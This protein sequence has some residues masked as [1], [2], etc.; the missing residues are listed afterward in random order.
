MKNFSFY[1]NML[2]ICFV[3]LTGTILFV[4][5]PFSFQS[6]LPKT[7]S[8][9]CEFSCDELVLLWDSAADATKCKE[10]LTA[11]PHCSILET[12]DNYM[13]ISVSAAES[14]AD[15]LTQIRT[16]PGIKAADPNYPLEL[17][18][19]DSNDFATVPQDT[20][21]NMEDFAAVSSTNLSSGFA[22][23]CNNMPTREVVVA[24][25]DTGVDTLHPMLSDFIWTNPDEIPDDG[26]DNDNN[27]YVDDINGW[28]FYHDDSSICHY[29]YSDDGSTYFPVEDDNDNH[30]THVAGIIASVLRGGDLFNTDAAPV[31]VKIMPLKIH[32][33]EKA[34]GSVANAIK[35]IKYAVMMDADVFNISWG[36]SAATSSI[37]TLEQTIR[38]SDL[39][40]LCAAGNTGSDN[41]LSPV[42]PASF[43]ADNVISVTFVNSY[44]FL[45]AK[46]NYGKNSVDIAAPGTDIYSTVVGDYAYMSGSSMSV[47]YVSGLAALIYSCYDNLYPATVREL[48]LSTA[49][50]L[51]YSNHFPLPVSMSFAKDNLIVPG[52]PNLQQALLAA[53]QQLSF[54]NTAPELAASTSYTKDFI[55]LNVSADDGNGSG[56]RIT[57]YANGTKTL[58]AFRRGTAGTQINDNSVLFAKA[59]KYTIY[60]SDYA[61]NES[62]LHYQLQDDTD[63]PQIAY[64]LH[65]SP[66]GNLHQLIARF[67]DSTGSIAAAYL[68]TGEYDTNTFPLKDAIPLPISN[69]RINYRIDT[70][71]SYTLYVEDTRGNTSTITLS[72]PQSETVQADTEEVILDEPHPF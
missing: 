40:F 55:R 62:I 4:C 32:G 36:S 42:Y 25:A 60:V 29:V 68:T 44:G 61:G 21:I 8:A 11:F 69:Q 58:H 52:I 64:Q 31:P 30:G 17:S 71:D 22:L 43:R 66:S 6:S 51:P 47:P 27:G 39:L 19:T 34:S 38:E 5:R 7:T 48:L 37:T 67:T 57:K 54:D 14:V 56:I 15:T 16:F 63:A 1:I 20:D 33:G 23:Y 12:L 72:I 49:Y 3:L 18:D 50:L 35:A 59:G 26:I 41:D 45:T 24:M 9:S 65:S 2:L 53:P 46:S 28:D 70:P 10:F 13:L